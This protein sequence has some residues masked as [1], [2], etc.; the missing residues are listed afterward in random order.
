M[1]ARLAA[2]K[3]EAVNALVVRYV[4]GQLSEPT[5]VVSLH[6]HIDVDEIRHLLILH[7][8]AHRNSLPF[9]RGDIA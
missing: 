4:T 5:F 7:Q 1:P 9:K 6:A 3:D 8:L 2:D